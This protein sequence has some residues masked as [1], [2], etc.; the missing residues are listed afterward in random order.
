MA[1]YQGVAVFVEYKGDKLLPI[2]LEGLGIGRKL[3]DDMGQ[4][5]SAVLAG[6]NVSGLVPQAI[7]GGADKVYV[8]DDSLLKDFNTDAYIAVMEKVVN[9]V[10]PLVLILGQTDVGRDLAPGLAFRLDTAVTMDCV[11][12]AID[13]STKRLL[14][15][16]PVYGGNAL[17]VFV[18][19]TDPQ[20]V[21]IRTKA[22]TALEPNAARKG[23]VINIAAGLEASAIRTKVLNREEEEVAGIKIEDA[24]N[25]VAGGR[26]IGSVEGFQ[27]LEELARLLKGAVGASR[28]ACDNGWIVDT[29]QVGLTGKIIAPELYIAVAISGSSQHMSGCFGAKTIIAINKDKE[30]N[31]FRH[32]RFGVVGDWKK[33]LPAFT[34]KVKELLAS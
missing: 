13:S 17:A 9:Q 32:A 34:A 23:E 14:Q 4:S 6:S 2:A 22:M 7:A 8:V 24:G 3:A 21:T 18:T 12:M 27:Q 25:V 16:K 20:I 28:P 30:A 1:D 10:K 15:T 26:G 19:E 31:I 33:V 5:L 11:E 29:A